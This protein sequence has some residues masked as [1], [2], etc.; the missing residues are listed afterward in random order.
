MFVF[1]GWVNRVK[2]RPYYIDNLYCS[3]TNMLSIP[4]IKFNGFQINLC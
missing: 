3:K 4:M 2:E 1:S